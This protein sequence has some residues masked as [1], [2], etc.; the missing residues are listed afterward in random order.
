MLRIANGEALTGHLYTRQIQRFGL[1]PDKPD[2]SY[3]TRIH[4]A[5]ELLSMAVRQLLIKGGAMGRLA[6]PWAKPITPSWWCGATTS[7]GKDIESSR[8]GFC[9]VWPQ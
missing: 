7:P 3:Q 9:L 5:Q 8:Q 4:Y 1:E 2:T 6:A